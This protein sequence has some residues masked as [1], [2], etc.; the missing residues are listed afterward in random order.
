MEVTNDNVLVYLENRNFCFTFENN[1]ILEDLP[2]I[3]ELMCLRDYK[4]YLFDED[5][6]QYYD[7][8]YKLNE[9][10]IHKIAKLCYVYEYVKDY[11]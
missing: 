11:I 8:Y 6:I 5:F 4:R 3:A 7:R 10:D 9:D 2:I 1:D